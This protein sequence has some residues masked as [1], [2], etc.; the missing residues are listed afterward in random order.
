MGLLRRFA[1]AVLNM[2]AQEPEPEGPAGDLLTQA[3]R[4][5][6]LKVGDVMKPRSDI[7]ALECQSTFEEIVRRF[8]DSEHSRMPVYRE[9]LDA[10]VGV[11]HIKDVFK[12]QAATPSRRPK[13]GDHVLT[14]RK[15]LVREPLYVPASMST[16]DLLAQMR[17]QHIHMALVI[18]EFGGTDGLVTLEDLLER[19][20]GDIADE[21]DEDAPPIVEDERGWVVD[22]RLLLPELEAAMGG[23]DL[24]PPDLDEEIDTVAG[25]VT[26]LA[27]R[28][29]RA[30]ERVPHPGG[31]E[32]EVVAADP[33]RVKR[34]RVHR[35][36][37]VEEPN[38]A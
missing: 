27:G 38:P 13:P 26:A 36:P 32:F 19:L 20:V 16:V 1:G 31:F 10:P 3:R 7:V 5:Q 12:L 29:P 6:D 2:Q 11:V 28:V 21:H 18:D 25:L 9:T 24:A 35:A 23:E 15:S 22:G 37:A 33:R 8:A 14:R 4:F 34:V 17:K 30:R